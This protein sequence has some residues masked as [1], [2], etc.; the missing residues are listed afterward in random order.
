VVGALGRSG[1]GGTMGPGDGG[2]PGSG[3]GIR[4]ENLK[5]AATIVGTGKE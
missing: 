1:P 4:A 2:P 3:G 5:W